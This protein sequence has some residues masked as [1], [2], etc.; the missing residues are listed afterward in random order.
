[1]PS[2]ISVT[3]AYTNRLFCFWEATLISAET[4]EIEEEEGVGV[5]DTP[6]TVL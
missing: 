5:F 4:E 2:T 1:M 3:P 6:A